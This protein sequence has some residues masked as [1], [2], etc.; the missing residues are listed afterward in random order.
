MR[1][2]RETLMFCRFCT[3]GSSSAVRVRKLA[4][5][6]VRD[7]V[8]SAV[9]CTWSVSPLRLYNVPFPWSSQRI[10]RHIP[11]ARQSSATIIF[12][13]P[14][15]NI[16]NFSPTLLHVGRKMVMDGEK[17]RY[18]LN[19]RNNEFRIHLAALMRHGMI[20]FGAGAK[21]PWPSKLFSAAH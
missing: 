10:I 4:F 3:F 16:C 21:N 1:T 7:R 17:E 6:P 14:F 15:V 2:V 12:S 13:R 18:G 8:F 5:S 9:S 19:M 11:R 20:H